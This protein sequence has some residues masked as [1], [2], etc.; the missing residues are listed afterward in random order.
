MLTKLVIPIETCLEEHCNS[1]SAPPQN[2]GIQTSWQY[3]CLCKSWGTWWRTRKY[4]R[5]KGLF[6]SF[7]YWIFGLSYL[8]QGWLSGS[9][10]HKMASLSG[11]ATQNCFGPTIGLFCPQQL[12]FPTSTREVLSLAT[13]LLVISPTYI[14]CWMILNKV[15]P[16]MYS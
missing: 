8:I 16:W 13:S 4:S 5:A 14:A 10:I 9:P 7:P 12:Y 1:D 11:F 3:A 2:S 6:Q 15:I